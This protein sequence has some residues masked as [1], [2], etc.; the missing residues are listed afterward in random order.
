[1][2]QPPVARAVR[3]ARDRTVP[4]RLLSALNTVDGASAYIVTR[5]ENAKKYHKQPIDIMGFHWA[6]SNY[7]WYGKD[8]TDWAIDKTSFANA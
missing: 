3:I 2:N 6:A 4:T 1:M 8:A 5:P 7:P